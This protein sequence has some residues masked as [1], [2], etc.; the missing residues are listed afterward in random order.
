MIKNAAKDSTNP[1]FKSQY[2]DL[3]SCWEAARVPLSSNG[4]SVAQGISRIEN[5]VACTTILMHESGQWLKDTMP[6]TPQQQ[7]PQGDGSCVTYVRR[8]TFCAMVGIS[9]GDDDGN[10]ASDKEPQKSVVQNLVVPKTT[11]VKPDT[12][13]CSSQIAMFDETNGGHA[14]AVALWCEQK[15]CKDTYRSMIE[16]MKGQPFTRAGFGMAW[17]KVNPET[18]DKEPETKLGV[19]DAAS[20]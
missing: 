12:A 7:T 18:P 16:A 3:A 13:T 5:K 20:K 19:S 11:Q 6:M 10:E 14:K 9:Q 15:K 2:A 4:L 1:H 17:A 8:Y